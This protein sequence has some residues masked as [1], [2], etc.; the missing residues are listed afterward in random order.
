MPDDLVNPT[1]QFE[2]AVPFSG[3]D[4]LILKAHLVI[5]RRLLEY[6]QCRVS[7]ALFQEIERPRDGSF[8]VR[9]LIARALSEQDPPEGNDGIAEIWKALDLLGRLRNEVAHT[10]ESTGT[11]LQDRM[12]VFIELVNRVHPFPEEKVLPSELHRRFRDSAA[13]LNALLST[14]A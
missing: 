2:S 5:E 13:Y 14:H 8:H 4:F 10:L 11:A 1:T 9:L 6:I 12:R 7:P 3:P